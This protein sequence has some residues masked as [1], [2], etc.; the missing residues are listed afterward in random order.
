MTLTLL[1]AG[2]AVAISFMYVM[3]VRAGS[4]S[5]ASEQTAIGLGDPAADTLSHG[6]YPQA[7]N[8]T[9]WHM[10]TVDDLTDAESLLDCLENQGIEERE[11]VVLG[12][13]CFAVR[14]R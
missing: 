1:I 5:L 4:P 14:W 7:A 2:A 3:T 9:D 12:N 6:N 8:S 13:S 10:T 11:L